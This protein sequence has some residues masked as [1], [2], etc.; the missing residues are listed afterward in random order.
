MRVN[1]ISDPHANWTGDKFDRPE[2]DCDLHLVVGDAADGLVNAI[3]I[4]AEAFKDSTAP[5][6]YI[7]GNHDY[8]ISEA[9]PNAYYQEQLERARILAPQLGVNLLSNDTLIVGNTLRVVDST[10]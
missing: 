9:E 1:V 5:V 4:V 8:Y 2:V 10:L 3:R 6:A 7:P